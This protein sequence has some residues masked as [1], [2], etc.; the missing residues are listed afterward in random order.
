MDLNRQHIRYFLFSQYLADGVRTT[1]EIVLPVFIAALFGHIEMG[2]TIALGALCVSVSDIPGPV[3]HKRNGMMYCIAFVFVIALLTGFL[4]KNVFL[5]GLLIACSSFFF[6]MFSIYGNRAAS[7]GTGALLVMILRLTTVAPPTEIIF[8]CLLILNG[9]VWYMAI[10]LLFFRVTPYRPAQRA[11]GECIHE[12]ANYLRIKAAFYEQKKDFKNE[13]HQLVAQQIIV[14]EKQDSLR[15]LL[16]KN[17]ELMEESTPQGKLLIL[18]FSDVMELYE[19]ITA[20]WYDYESLHEKFGTKGILENISEVIKKIA[21][22]MDNIGLAIQSNIAVKKQYSLVHDLEII[23][24]QTAALG[25]TDPGNMVLKNIM[26][27]LHNIGNKLDELFNYF[28]AGK[29]TKRNLQS[30]S[31]YNQFVSHQQIDFPLFRNNLNLQSAVFRHSLRMMITCIAGFIIANLIAFSHHSYWIL[32][33]I[34]IILKPGFGLTKERNVQ[35]LLG[36]IGGAAIGLLILAFIKDSNIL[37]ALIIFFMLG[38]YT[39]LRLNYIVMVIF[40][41]P[42]VLILFHLL[43][44]PFWDI[45][46]ERLLDTVIGCTLAFLASYLLFPHWQSTEVKSYMLNVIKANIDYLHKL[47]EKMCGKEIAVLDYKLVRKELYVS[48]ANLS[49]AFHRM[50][51]DPK[52]KQQNT[53]HTDQFVVLNHILSSNVASLSAG[54][55]HSGIKVYP[56]EIL[57]KIKMAIRIMEKTLKT[58]DTSKEPDSISDEDFTNTIESKANHLQLSNQLDFINKIALDINKLSLVLVA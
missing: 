21:T 58:L 26:V 40:L 56:E 34:I 29:N 32:L 13:Y 7:V 53:S 9:G 57:Q 54:I 6:T 31:Y 12:M 10:A 49:A 11:L 2:Y 28:L 37:Y 48:I 36:T 4:N 46:Q 41:T 20:T 8:D 27:N 55:N 39:F 51:N 30:G 18:T 16:Y 38:T 42:Y 17:R 23:S 47:K 43:G 5:L 45:A 25:D 35:R 19:Q 3:E 24:S 14:N 33:T 44:L 15:E 1:L 52:N 50:L 22:E